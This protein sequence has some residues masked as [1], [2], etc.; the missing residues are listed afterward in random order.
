M[1]VPKHVSRPVWPIDS[2]VLA[3]NLFLHPTKDLAAFTQMSQTLRPLYCVLS[4]RRLIGEF[5]HDSHFE[6]FFPGPP[7][8][9]LNRLV[10]RVLGHFV[11]KDRQF[12]S[13]HRDADLNFVRAHQPPVDPHDAL[14]MAE[15]PHETS[16]ECV[17]VD[18]ADRRHWKGNQPRCETHEFFGEGLQIPAF[19]NV[20]ACEPFQIEAVGKK[21]WVRR[22]GYKGVRAIIGFNIVQRAIE[23]ADQVRGPAVLAVSQC[24][25]AHVIAALEG[26]KVAHPAQ[27]RP[28]TTSGVRCRSLTTV[29]HR[30]LGTRQE[31]NWVSLRAQRG[32]L[33]LPQQVQRARG[34]PPGPTPGWG[35]RR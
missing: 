21:L 28:T 23:V 29:Q 16:T 2:C 33:A 22:S 26:N 13:R 25:H 27:R 20:V 35:F 3:P 5:L 32:A 10:E 8:G 19:V 18:R 9:K 11:T 14:V 24:D 17:A 7:F 1:H 34:H 6:R 4:H 31:R 12:G 30:T 15:C